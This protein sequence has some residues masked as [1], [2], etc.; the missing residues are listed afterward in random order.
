MEI[1]AKNQVSSTNCKKKETEIEGDRC[2]EWTLYIKRDVRDITTHPYLHGHINKLL[3]KKLWGNEK[4]EGWLDIENIMHAHTRYSNAFVTTCLKW[5][6]THKYLQKK[7]YNVSDF[8][9]KNMGRTELDGAAAGAGLATGQWLLGS[10][11]ETGA[12][13]TLCCILL[14]FSI[15]RFR[16]HRESSSL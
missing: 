5:S 15:K 10:V 11:T 9:Q 3:K 1:S 8:L 6:Y 14:K 13:L 16:N 2:E 7:S 12:F 4:P